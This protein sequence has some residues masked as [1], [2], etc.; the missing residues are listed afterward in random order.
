MF[1]AYSHSPR[2][3]NGFEV[4]HI[5]F[6]LPSTLFTAGVFL[7]IRQH[8]DE[9]IKGVNA[10]NRVAGGLCI[11]EGEFSHTSVNDDI[12]KPCFELGGR[13]YAPMER[14]GDW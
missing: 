6:W 13:R 9:D 5:F 10:E 12:I 14:V 2:P 1:V 11:Y 8:I 4:R 3:Q 7:E